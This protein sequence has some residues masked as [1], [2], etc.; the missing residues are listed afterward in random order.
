MLAGDL[1]STLN[2]P[3]PA[4]GNPIATVPTSAAGCVGLHIPTA[5]DPNEGARNEKNHDLVDRCE[6]HT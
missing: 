3:L 2:T 5:G 4:L 1:L 6:H